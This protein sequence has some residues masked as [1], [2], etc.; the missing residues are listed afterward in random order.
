MQLPLVA[1]DL[2]LHGVAGYAGS[3]RSGMVFFEE[4]EGGRREG[5][6]ELVWN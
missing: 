4:E 1:F 5:I 6:A 3:V 2:F